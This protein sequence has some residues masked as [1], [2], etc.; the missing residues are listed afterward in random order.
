MNWMTLR[1]HAGA[2]VRPV[3][4]RFFFFPHNHDCRWWGGWTETEGPTVYRENTGTSPGK[5]GNKN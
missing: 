1:P 5:N 2:V 4:A 3:G